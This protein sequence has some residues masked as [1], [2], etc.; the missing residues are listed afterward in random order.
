MEARFAKLAHGTVA[1]RDR[2]AV[3]DVF[4]IGGN[5][6][7][8]IDALEP[9]SVS[10]PVVVSSPFQNIVFNAHSHH[11]PRTVRQNLSRCPNRNISACHNL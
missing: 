6:D 11:T 7:P 3:R 1:L 8:A 4:T 5:L 2:E 9:L 10:Y